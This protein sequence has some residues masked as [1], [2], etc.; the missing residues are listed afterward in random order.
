M[1]EF[2][3][4]D[5]AHFD[6]LTEWPYA[7]RYHRWADLRVH[8]VDEGPA[9]G[10]VA[11]L[12]HGMPTWGYLYRDMIPPLVAAGYR[13]IA[14]DHLGFGRS[15][16]PTDFHWYSIGRHVEVL[17]SLISDLDLQNVMLVCQ[18]WGGPIGLAQAALMPERFDRLVIMNTWLHHPEY[19]YSDR[20]K[21]WIQL[22][23]PGGPLAVEKPRVGLVPLMDR[24]LL[25]MEQ[26]FAA[27][28]AAEEPALDGEIGGAYAAW[29]APFR[30]LSDA[31]FNGLRKFPL[32]IPLHDPV[33]GTGPAQTAHFRTL[34]EWDKP[35]HM[36]WGESDVI[37]TA[38]WGRSWAEL[39]GATYDGIPEAH[40]FLQDSHGTDIV[41]LLLARIAG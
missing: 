16:K 18:D 9:D 31:G 2:E 21:A 22:W 25:S 37:F 34:L 38:E 14:P 35:V 15:D 7:P 4:T 39:M 32:S 8:Y 10:P 6:A 40:H 33:S 24:G 1:T 30:G 20:I 41:D 5:D 3:R 36:I 12:M 11:L 23:E 19:E 29:S 28:G 27:M 17:T 26:A 13:C